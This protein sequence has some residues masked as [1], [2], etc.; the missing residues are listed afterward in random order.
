VS[1]HK[2]CQRKIFISVTEIVKNYTE[3]GAYGKDQDGKKYI[4]I[5]MLAPLKLFELVRQ[6]ANPPFGVTGEL[7]HK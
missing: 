4:V 5:L 6:W 2:F 3:A 7:R 1:L